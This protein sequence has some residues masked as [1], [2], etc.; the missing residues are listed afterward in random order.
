MRTLKML[1]T[2][3][4]VK[5]IPIKSQYLLNLFCNKKGKNK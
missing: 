1:F 2:L 4:F 3:I 5:S